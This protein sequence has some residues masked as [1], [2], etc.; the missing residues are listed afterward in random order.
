VSGK[1]EAV[2]MGEGE[3]LEQELNTVVVVQNNV[4]GVGVTKVVVDCHD[5]RS[6]CGC[7]NLGLD[8]K[9]SKADKDG[10][11][12]NLFQFH[13]LDKGY[14]VEV[15][16]GN[17]LDDEDKEDQKLNKWELAEECHF[18]VVTLQPVFELSHQVHCC[19]QGLVKCLQH[20]TGYYC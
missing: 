8:L 17:K 19:E 5:E 1:L 9:L 11:K 6:P 4:V 12:G 14:L 20:L 16:D 13:E 18:H 3:L 10:L 2:I 7:K 15:K